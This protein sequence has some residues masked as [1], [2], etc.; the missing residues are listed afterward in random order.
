[1]DYIFHHC[2]MENRMPKCLGFSTE[3][4]ITEGNEYVP[5]E[6]GSVVQSS[7]CGKY[8]I[9]LKFL[10]SILKIHENFTFD[11]IRCP[12]FLI[13]NILNYKYLRKKLTLQCVPP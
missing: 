5:F 7:S 10:G 8:G 13:Q 3:V 9:S 12:Y 6:S 4:L 11:F 1:M 2:G